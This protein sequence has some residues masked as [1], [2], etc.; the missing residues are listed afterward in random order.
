MKQLRRGELQRKHFEDLRHFCNDVFAQWITRHNALTDDLAHEKLARADERRSLT[1][2]KTSLESQLETSLDATQKARDAFQ[3]QGRCLQAVVDTASK[4]RDSLQQQLQ[5]Q[6]TRANQLQDDMGDLDQQRR[7]L[8]ARLDLTTS[9][10]RV[11]EDELRVPPVPSMF[12]DAQ[13]VDPLTRLSAMNLPDLLRLLEEQNAC[14][15]LLT[16]KL[17][18]ATEM[19]T[20]LDKAK[21]NKF[22]VKQALRCKDEAAER[23]RDERR[24]REQGGEN[25]L[26]ICC[27]DKE[28]SWAIYPCGHRDFC[29]EC[30]NKIV[31]ESR[32]SCCPVCRREA[33]ACNRIFV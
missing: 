1:E 9:Q 19:K 30:A 21:G 13:E 6:R 25:D 8:E 29:E 15:R 33:L 16:E 31:G 20:N 4:D 2:E 22:L 18:K 14:V 7:T 24:K 12:A 26:C 17:G 3:E 10:K 32:N 23:E 5:I 28:K 27:S 11:L